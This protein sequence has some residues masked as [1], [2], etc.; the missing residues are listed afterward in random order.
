MLLCCV[1]ADAAELHYAATDRCPACAVARAAHADECSRCWT[2]HR[3]PVSRYRDL[4]CELENSV[5][6]LDRSPDVYQLTTED[7]QLLTAALPEAI[8]YRQEHDGAEDRA[9]LAAYRELVLA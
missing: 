1:L 4:R 6:R 7:R 2:I 3:G 9:L 8:T 5:G